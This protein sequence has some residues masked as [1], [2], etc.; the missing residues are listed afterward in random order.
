MN[1][2]TCQSHLGELLYAERGEPLEAELAD[3]LR[4]HLRH[5]PDC[6]QDFAELEQVQGA[7]DA[8]VD[9]PSAPAKQRISVKAY[10]SANRLHRSR[11]AWR[12]ATCAAAASLLV[13]AAGV[14]WMWA[15]GQLGTSPAAANSIVGSAQPSTDW[16]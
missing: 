9:S 16:G 11:N 15:R 3:R 12:A 1:C 14:T 7:L 8:L 2:E 5:C 13:L 4:G 10:A 6:A